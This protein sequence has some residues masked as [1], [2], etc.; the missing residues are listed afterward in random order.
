MKRTRTKL[1]EAQAKIGELAIKVDI[2][3][4]DPLRPEISNKTLVSHLHTEGYNI[5]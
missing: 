5:L 2:L 1:M 4:K 3:Q